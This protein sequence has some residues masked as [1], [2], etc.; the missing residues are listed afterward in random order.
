MLVHPDINPVALALGPVKIH[1]YGIMYLLGFWGAWWLAIQRGRKPYVAFSK[2]AVS[3]L[4]FY[5]VLGVILGGRIGYTFFYNIDTQGRLVFFH[6]PMVIF[7]I[8]EGGMS[9]HGGLIGVIVSMLV[10]AHQRKLRFFYVADIVAVVVPVGLFTGR[11]GN[12]INSELWGAPTNLPWG[13]VFP[14]TDPSGLPRHPSM[15]YEAFLEGLVMLAILWWV[16]RKPRPQGTLAGL[17][18]LLYSVFRFAIEF[19]RVPD[20]QL[21]YL[22]GTG[23]FTMGMQLCVPMFVAGLAIIVY[24]YSKPARTVTVG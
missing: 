15:L 7:R 23:W 1:W 2:E 18:L 16:G 11:I 22:Y 5:I 13:M 21:G 19:V 9:F 6:D 20:K 8:W 14:A 4:L 17:F 12:F 24:A 3:D 10:Y